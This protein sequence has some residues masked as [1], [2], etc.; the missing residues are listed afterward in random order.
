MIDKLRPI[1]IYCP[2]PS[3]DAAEA[4]RVSGVLSRREGTG[5]AW[6]HPGFSQINIYH[7]APNERENWRDLRQILSSPGNNALKRAFGEKA[8]QRYKAFVRQKIQGNRSP[9]LIFID[10]RQRDRMLGFLRDFPFRTGV[11][12]E[13][14]TLETD[15]VPWWGE[16]MKE[17]EAWDLLFDTL[18]PLGFST[19][20]LMGELGVFGPTHRPE[21]CVYSA[22]QMFDQHGFRTVFLRNFIF[23][24]AASP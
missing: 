21:G 14:P 15:V 2:G 19:I 6:V 10:R 8:Y 3:Y 23:P 13:V 5:L 24:N 16:P 1:R 11:A 4:K 12:I 20:H 9:L 7:P 18:R 17:G 22:G